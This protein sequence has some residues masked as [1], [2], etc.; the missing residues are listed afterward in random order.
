MIHTETVDSI[1]NLCENMNKFKLSGSILGLQ[2]LWDILDVEQISLLENADADD[3]INW[4]HDEQ[5]FTWKSDNMKIMLSEIYDLHRSNSDFYIF[6]F[7]DTLMKLIEVAKSK[8]ISKYLDHMYTKGIKRHTEWS[9]YRID[10]EMKQLNWMND[11]VE[12]NFAY[13]EGDFGFFYPDEQAMMTSHWEAVCELD[14]SEYFKATHSPFMFN[15]DPEINDFGNHPKVLAY[16]HSGATFAYTC[17]VM[18]D[19]C[20]MGWSEFVYDRIQFYRTVTA[21]GRR[22]LSSKL[23]EMHNFF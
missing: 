18:H 1:L 2:R 13:S 22:R 4:N 21:D 20:K 9:H 12:C 7:Q 5:T 16:G 8:S 14:L 17:H 11:V 10:N 23:K 6:T 15:N 19:I 3:I